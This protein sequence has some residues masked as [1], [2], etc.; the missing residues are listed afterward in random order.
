LFVSENTT[1]DTK[2]QDSK[3]KNNESFTK[4]KANMERL[5]QS[6]PERDFAYFMMLGFNGV[7]INHQRLKD[8]K[9]VVSKK[10]VETFVNVTL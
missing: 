5:K 6:P 7:R 1:L 2:F 10:L 8:G 9:D 4:L 3:C